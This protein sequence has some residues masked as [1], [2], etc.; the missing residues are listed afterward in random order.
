MESAF[1]NKVA[2]VTGGSFG[3]GRAAAVAFARKGAKVAVVDWIED[4]E[5]VYLIKKAGS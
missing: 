2:I 3:I 5:T 1:K 4:N